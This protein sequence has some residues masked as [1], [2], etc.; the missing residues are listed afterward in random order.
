MHLKALLSQASLS[1][2]NKYLPTA[3]CVPGT[4]INIE[5]NSEQCE[6]PIL[7]KLAFYL[8]GRM[9]DR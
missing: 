2:F 7:K 3:Y 8:R 9:K 6:V 5:D 1:H 4:S